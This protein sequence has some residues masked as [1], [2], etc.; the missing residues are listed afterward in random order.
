MTHCGHRFCS[1]GPR[2]RRLRRIKVESR[3]QSWS[4]ILSTTSS[5]G[6]ILFEKRMNSHQKAVSCS[7]KLYRIRTRTS[8]KGSAPPACTSVTVV[9]ATEQ[10]YVHNYIPKILPIC[11]LTWRRTS[12]LS[13]ISRSSSTASSVCLQTLF[14]SQSLWEVSIH[15][16][17]VPSV[18]LLHASLACCSG[19]GMVEIQEWILV[20]SCGSPGQ[21]ANLNKGGGGKKLHVCVS[22]GKAAQVT[23]KSHIPCLILLFSSTVLYTSWR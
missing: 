2:C 16:Q 23:L 9:V 19:K 20:D 22:W 4:R 13:R 7:T 1:F 14:P 3:I 6:S 21:S 18:T 11:C 5:Q 17:Y 8:I 12:R 15:Q 10:W